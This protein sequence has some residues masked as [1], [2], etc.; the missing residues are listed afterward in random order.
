MLPK[1]PKKIWDVNVD[2]IVI[3]KLVK[4]KTNCKYLIGYL[5]KDIK[6]LVLIMPKMSGYVK[7]FKVEDKNS[8]LMSFRI[9]DDK[10]LEKYKAIWTKIKSLKC[11]V[12]ILPVYDVKYI[13]TNT[14]TYGDKVYTNFHGLNVPEDDIEYE[15]FTF[16]I[17]KGTAVGTINFHCIRQPRGF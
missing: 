14:R 5:D 8:K 11:Q 17:Q 10:L 9:D 13:K 15:S 12:N 3:P 2:N 4:T 16:C 1:K 7:K 6:P